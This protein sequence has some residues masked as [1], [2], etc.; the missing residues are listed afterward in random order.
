M[1]YSAQ[2]NKDFAKASRNMHPNNK[3]Q[4]IRKD[5]L[6]E[7]DDIKENSNEQSNG[8]IDLNK[9]RIELRYAKRKYREEFYFDCL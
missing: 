7:S 6:E 3:T 8:S 4:L 2:Y 9:A 1:S 5:S